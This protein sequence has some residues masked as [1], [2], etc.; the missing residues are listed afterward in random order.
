MNRAPSPNPMMT[1]P[2][3]RPFLSGN[4]FATVVTGVT[5]PRP[6]PMPP[7]RPYPR[8]SSG[9]E[10]SARARPAMAYPRLNAA[11]PRVAMRR[12]PT[13]CRRGPATAAETPRKKIARAKIHATCEFDQP[14]PESFATSMAWKKLHAYTVPRQSC[15]SVPMAAISQRF[16]M[17]AVLP[18]MR[19]QVK[20]RGAILGSRFRAGSK[21]R[22]G[23]WRRS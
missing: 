16:L 21:G 5:Y 12:G 20:G 10:R 2:V 18:A 3:A 19:W 11:P 1:M 23:A 15:S 9:S 4:H 13:F 17:L 7:T 14:N 22:D 8:Y 6:S